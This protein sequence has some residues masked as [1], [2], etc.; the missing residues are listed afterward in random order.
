MHLKWSPVLC[1]DSEMAE[2]A[3]FKLHQL[4][5]A[6]DACTR[7]Y[8]Q[9]EVGSEADVLMRN[10]RSEEEYC[11]SFLQVYRNDYNET[12]VTRLYLFLD[13]CFRIS[14]SDALYYFREKRVV[15]LPLIAPPIA[16]HIRLPT[17]VTNKIFV[18]IYN[19][20]LTDLWHHL[21]SFHGLE[22]VGNAIVV[23][24]QNVPQL[25]AIKEAMWRS[26]ASIVDKQGKPIHVPIGESNL[27]DLDKHTDG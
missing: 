18:T 7:K 16:K 5:S 2:P 14:D 13:G 26:C 9:R 22:H 25:N 19:R 6:Y 24:F 27:R 23:S 3:A 4:M 20:L 10:D 12:P 11:Y 8:L 21:F 15:L 17:G 1:H